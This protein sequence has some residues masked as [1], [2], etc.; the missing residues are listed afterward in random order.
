MATRLVSTLQLSAAALTGVLAL[1]QVRGE[2]VPLGNPRNSQSGTDGPEPAIVGE[3]G[4][5]A[6]HEGTMRLMEDYKNR[7][8][9]LADGR[10]ADGGMISRNQ[11]RGMFQGPGR[12]EQV[13]AFQKNCADLAT[14]LDRLMKA[15]SICDVGFKVAGNL[16]EGDVSGAL[17]V[18]PQEL[19]KQLCSKLG[20][21][22]GTWAAG[23]FGSVGGA[24][25]G[26]EAWSNSGEVFFERMAQQVRYME[27]TAEFAG[28]RITNPDILEYMRG[29]ITEKELRRR[30]AE[31][32]A[33]LAAQASGPA[34]PEGVDSLFFKNLKRNQAEDRKNAQAAEEA[35]MRAIDDRAREA[36]RKLDADKPVIQRID[37]KDRR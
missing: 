5:I 11:Q 14:K 27:K 32:R 19:G 13:K 35:R 23:P 34:K 12:G 4:T 28:A 6:S 21:F 2:T 30:L 1:A 18:V 29:N 33:A 31:Q 10:D 20:A 36:Q 22:F 3:V 17:I 37:P 7:L 26:E 15:I 9:H 25:L 16:V 24:A 8:A